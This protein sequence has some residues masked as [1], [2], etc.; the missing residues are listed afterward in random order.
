MGKPDK[1][2]ATCV[3]WGDQAVL[4]K[5]QSGSGKSALGLTLLAYGCALVA[6]DYVEAYRDQDRITVKPPQAISGLIEARGVGILN[7]SHAA[8]AQACLVVDLDQIEIER[9]PQRRM[10][11]LLGC[12]LPLIYRVEGPLFAPAIL[13]I[14]KAGWSD[15]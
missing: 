13:Q 12:D 6:D 10:I 1:I 2:H 7:A 14:L 9:L 11:T 3:A 5:G 15:R 4:I 8:Q